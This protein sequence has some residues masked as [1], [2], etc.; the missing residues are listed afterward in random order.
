MAP[1]CGNKPP[2]SNTN[3]LH[4]I[5][6]I[7]A[8]GSSSASSRPTTGQQ[9]D[10]RHNPNYDQR[11]FIP[12]ITQRDIRRLT[13]RTTQSNEP[14]PYILVR[15]HVAVLGLGSV[16]KAIVQHNRIIFI[17]QNDVEIGVKTNN[18]DQRFLDLVEKN[19]KQAYRNAILQHQ[20]QQQSLEEMPQSDSNLGFEII[21]YESLFNIVMSLIKQQYDTCKQATSDLVKQIGNDALLSVSLQEKMRLLK[22]QV[23]E[24]TNRCSTYCQLLTDIL[25][26]SEYNDDFAY[27]YLSEL[28]RDPYLYK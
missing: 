11:D 10:L 16:M 19:I 7:A 1:T 12:S 26:S 17:T 23:R 6:G 2:L 27:L 13:T 28:Y 4:S 24:L 18:K 9:H 22:D 25:Q 8:A 3:P 20:K 14:A 21:T 15:R 5:G